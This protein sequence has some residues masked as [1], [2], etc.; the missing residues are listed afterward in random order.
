MS[1]ILGQ[2][3]EYTSYFW[4][5]MET[6]LVHRHSHVQVRRGKYLLVLRLT[7]GQRPGFCLFLPL[8][9]NLT[10]ELPPLEIE[11][12]YAPLLRSDVTFS[13]T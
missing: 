10:V 5:L 8:H 12:G 1:K 3:V 2:D 11:S 7:N 13:L 6:V 4:T 9:L